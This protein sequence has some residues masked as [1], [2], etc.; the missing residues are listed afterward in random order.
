MRVFWADDPRY[1]RY[2]VVHSRRV[3]A[4]NRRPTALR[5]IWSQ[6]QEAAIIRMDS[7]EFCEGERPLCLLEIHRGP[8]FRK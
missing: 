2:K 4:E 6:L 5:V 1:F 7:L 8:G 3:V